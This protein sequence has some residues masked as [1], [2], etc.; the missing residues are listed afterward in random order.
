MTV[1]SP[2]VTESELAESIT[3]SEAREAMNSYRSIAI[4]ASAIADAIA[5]ALSQPAEVDVNEMIVRPAAT[6]Q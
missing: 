3:D 5:F 4:P 1:I 2:G 6:V